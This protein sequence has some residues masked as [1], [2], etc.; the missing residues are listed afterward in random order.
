MEGVWTPQTLLWLR[1]CLQNHKNLPNFGRDLENFRSISCLILG[2]GSKHP[3]FF[4][5]AQ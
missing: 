3:L 5:G 2:L 4:I 1:H